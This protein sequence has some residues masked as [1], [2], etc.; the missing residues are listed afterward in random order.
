MN[1]RAAG[2]MGEQLAA[3]YLEKQGYKIL[4]R[5]ASYGDCEVDIICEAYLDENGAPIVE[6]RAVSFL[7][8]L[9]R[10]KRRGQRTLVFCEV[11]ARAGDAYGSGA[12]A[13]TPYKAGRY[14]VAAKTYQAAHGCV[15]RATRFDIIEVAYDEVHH[16]PD[17]FNEN[18]AKYP[19]KR[20]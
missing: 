10:K 14:I 8:G 12:E 19:R 6:N 20:Y 3:E 4:E 5:N 18:D 11:K 7:R 1:T 16:I 2:V 17:A 15:G 9:L 13:V